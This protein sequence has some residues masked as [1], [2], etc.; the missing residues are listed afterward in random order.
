MNKTELIKDLRSITQAGMSDCKSALEEAQWDLQK[1]IDIVKIKGL[2]T[3]SGREGKVAAEGAVCVMS[4]SDDK[5]AVMVELNCQTDFV[6]QNPEFKKLLKN[7]TMAFASSLKAGVPNH[8]HDLKML[9]N[10]GPGSA[11]MFKSVD[12]LR[13]ELIALTKENIVVRRWW[14]EEAGPACKIFTYTHT[15]NKIGVI[16]SMQAPSEEVLNSPEFNALGAD[17]AMQIAAMNPVSVSRERVSQT[18]L[19][20][21]KDIFETQLKELNKPQQAWAKIL[22]GKFNKW[23]TEV[24]LLDQESVVV[25]KSS[26]NDLIKSLSIKLGGEVRVVNFHRCQ[27]GEGVEVVKENLYALCHHLTIKMR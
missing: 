11:V 16:L 24:C 22:E 21:Q 10:V 23:F 2:N 18:E 1:A 13:K 9:C 17:I 19:D 7:I 12:E 8:L 20:R 15:N 4:S 6:A 5:D 14:A 27:V 25:P 26:I 3:V